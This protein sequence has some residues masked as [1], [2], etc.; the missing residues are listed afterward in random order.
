MA[1][2]GGRTVLITLLVCTVTPA[3]KRPGGLLDASTLEKLVRSPDHLDR[4][5]GKVAI[6][7]F[8]NAITAL[9]STPNLPNSTTSTT[10]MPVAMLVNP[11]SIAKS[12]PTSPTTAPTAQPSHAPTRPAKPA[13]PSGTVKITKVSQKAGFRVGVVIS[14][15]EDNTHACEA[16]SNG[17]VCHKGR[18]AEYICGCKVGYVCMNDCQTCLDPKYQN[19]I[20]SGITP[21]E[22]IQRKIVRVAEQVKHNKQKMKRM[23]TAAKLRERLKLLTEKL[24]RQQKLVQRMKADETGAATQPRFIKTAAESGEDD[25][26]VLLPS[27]SDNK[28][29]PSMQVAFNP[30]IFTP[31][32][33]ALPTASPT[34]LISIDQSKSKGTLL[35]DILMSSLL[36]PDSKGLEGFNVPTPSVIPKALLEPLRKGSAWKSKPDGLGLMKR[37]DGLASSYASQKEAPRHYRSDGLAPIHLPSNPTHSPTTTRLVRKHHEYGIHISEGQDAFHFHPHL[38]LLYSK[39][40]NQRGR[41]YSKVSN[42]SRPLVPPA[43]PGVAQL[44]LQRG[45]SDDTIFLFA[46][47]PAS[48]IM[49]SFMLTEWVKGKHVDTKVI[50]AASATPQ[51][52]EV[53][54]FHDGTIKSTGPGTIPAGAAIHLA[55]VKLQSAF[56]DGRTCF[57]IREPQLVS[58]NTSAGFTTMTPRTALCGAGKRRT[59]SPTPSPT[60]N[61]CQSTQYRLKQSCQD[62]TIC[63][64]EQF[65][66]MPPTRTSDR[67]CS[68]ATPCKIDEYAAVGLSLAADR[69]CERISICSPVE[70]ESLPPTASTD[71]KCNPQPD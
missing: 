64:P 63:E 32:P 18:G 41:N 2:L 59:S 58:A 31:S 55:T 11:Q 21:E 3:A 53:F 24:G 70:Y 28:F 15:C 22:V 45:A 7:A 20:L 27:P 8:L 42:A 51:P 13:P 12:A 25:D 9:V 4:A 54:T 33:T 6:S 14:P 10:Q 23:A 34:A 60:K 56:Y 38:N 47:F 48:M 44:W 43:K 29:D 35:A 68:D 69:I 49:W 16:A 46:N 67:K 30:L 50:S 40:K 1:V 19:A 66:T 26:E 65:Q 57:G 39:S 36:G 61:D 37:R 62:A 71:R 17:G 52:M 5:E